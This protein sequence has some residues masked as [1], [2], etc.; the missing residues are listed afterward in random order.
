MKSICFKTA[1]FL[2][3]CGLLQSADANRRSSIAQAAGP[4]SS[5]VLDDT[6]AD[7]NSQNQDLANNSVWLF[8]G[9][10]TTV[11]TDQ[12]GSVGFDVTGTGTS[13]EGF[14]AFFT[15]AGSPI[16]LGV[17]DKLSVSVTFSLSGFRANGQD[18]R[19]GVLD[20][21]GTR[22]TNNL[23][24][25]QNDA[26]FIGD[27]GYGLQFY[28]SRNGNP[29]VLGHRAVLTAANLFNDFGNFA[30]ING[31]GATDRQPLVED[32]PYTLTYTIERLSEINTRLSASVT[33]GVL[34]DYNYSG[35][36][37]SSTPSTSFDYFAFRIAGTN[38]TNQIAF[39]EL[40]VRYTPAAPVITSQPQPSSLTVQVGSNVTMAVG[41]G[42]SAL[43]Y[44]WQKDGKPISGNNSA[45]TATLN[46]TEVK[47]SDAGSYTATIIN[48]GGSVT[49]SP[50][51]LKV[52]NSP[53]PPAPVVTTQPANTTVTLGDSTS[54]SV[55]A[56]GNA[57]FYQWFKNGVLI[58]NASAGRLT[59]QNAKVGDSAS[60]YVVVS[61][62]SGSISSSSATLLVVSAMT[63][64]SV[65]PYPAEIG[66]CVDTPLYMQFDQA[67]QAGKTGR[68]R[69]YSSAGTVVDT[70]DMAANPQTRLIGGNSFAYFPVMVSGNT[71]T[72]K[73]H[74]QLPYGDSYYVTVEPGVFTDPDGAP[75]RG[76]ADPIWRFSTRDS[77]PSAGTTALTVAADGSGDFCT[78]QGAIDF[79]PAG[80]TQPTTI[81]VRSGTYTEIVYVAST[82]PFITVRGDD[83]DKTVIQ[84][85]NNNNVNPSTV[86]RSLFGAD[87]SDFTLENITLRNSTPHL[88]S[89]AESFR[90]NANRVLLNRVSL[91]SFQDTLLMQGG[92]FVTDSFIEGDVDFMWGTGPVF[93]QNS[94]LK[95]ATSGGYYTQIRNGMEQAGFV[96]LNDRL[97]SEPEVTNMYLSRIDPTVF[98]YSQVVYINSAMGTHIIPAGWLLNN[99]MIAPDV[100]FWEY[101]STDLDGAPL[102]VSQRAAFSRQLTS[103]E[104]AQWSDPA[105]VLG[106]WVP[107]TVNATA[108]MVNPGAP[109]IVDWSAAAGHAATDSIGLYASGNPDSSPI[110]WQQIGSANTGRLTFTMPV[111]PGQYDFR[112]IQS[113]GSARAAASGLVTVQ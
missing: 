70:I 110:S 94:E 26:T 3:I 82:K 59:F 66:D 32:T 84:Y 25:G 100:R 1:L 21:Q 85:P 91:Y 108:A 46:L 31:S 35:V 10:A 78:V 56:T 2:S 4:V 34:R 54:L 22:N 68:I 14:W 112:L 49:S 86:G 98:P 73:L 41:A 60:Y 77:V 87:G 36:E 88:G 90:S 17:G 12:L 47:L 20:S 58:P 19:W 53:V 76:L 39:S 74:G 105:F 18:I 16:V 5:I 44:Q 30:T 45:A 72:I 64:T 37:S 15:N 99:A 79:V 109:L 75:Y 62:S 6:F 7:G 33:G 80:N 11:R 101:K 103:Q 48:A 23:T 97:T 38:F 63:A 92:G 28:A 24:G 65:S 50:V 81:T 9:R 67:P 13:S 42:G 27:T 113:G 40:L 83:R 57:L 93:I 89:Q 95:A 43:T 107:N 106:G 52:S 61:N 69:V 102:D 29:F 8:N 71:A 51:T 96:Y 55:A 104:A 111:T